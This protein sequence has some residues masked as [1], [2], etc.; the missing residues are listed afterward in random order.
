LDPPY[1]CSGT[2]RVHPGDEQRGKGFL[3]RL[4]R[5]LIDDFAIHIKDNKQRAVLDS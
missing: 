4:N 2:K 3:D 5:K 1:F